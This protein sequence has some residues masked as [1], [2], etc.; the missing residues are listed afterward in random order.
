MACP[1]LT[2]IDSIYLFCLK[3]KFFIICKE[4]NNNIVLVKLQQI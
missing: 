3:K 4:K 2:D 1:L